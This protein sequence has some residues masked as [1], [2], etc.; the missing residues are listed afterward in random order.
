MVTLSIIIPVYNL[1]LYIRR[2]LNSVI[3]QT[4]K[5]L[6]IIVVN[7][8][9]KDGSL[10]ILEEYASKDSRVKVIDKENGGVTS[11][12]RVGLE[13]AQG[14]YVFFLDGDDW[15]ENETLDRLY[16]CA[17][18]KNAEI[19]LGNVYFSSDTKDE[20]VLSSSFDSIS[21]KEF[22]HQLA[23]GEQLWSLCMKLIKTSVC[24]KM[25]IPDTLSMAED[26]TGML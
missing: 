16:S 8:G 17:K 22:I 7:D 9:S 11:C 21:F 4:Y 2:C 23:R 5:E 25:I 12:R 20:P 6:E 15:L 13:Q 26:M 18:A 24:R 10:K 14:E 3:E 1:E 19:V